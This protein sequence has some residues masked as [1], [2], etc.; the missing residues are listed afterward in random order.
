[1]C[2]HANI[3]A[4]E[5]TDST[6]VVVLSIVTIRL[7][8][9]KLIGNLGFDHQGGGACSLIFVLEEQLRS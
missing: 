5:M 2:N 6:R 9:I 7:L 3:K 1:M 8:D 4:C